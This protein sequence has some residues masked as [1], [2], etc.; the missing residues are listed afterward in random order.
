MEAFIWIG[1][2]VVAVQALHTFL[3]WVNCRKFDGEMF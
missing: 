3:E 2:L 1:V